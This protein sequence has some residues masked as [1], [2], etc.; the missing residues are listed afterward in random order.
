MY[1]PK[2]DF[3]LVLLLK[4]NPHFFHQFY[5]GFKK[6][7]Q[8]LRSR[9][10]NQKHEQVRHMQIVLYLCHQSSSQHLNLA[11]EIQLLFGNNEEIDRLCQNRYIHV[12]LNI[13]F[14]SLLRWL[15]PAY[16]IRLLFQHHR[17][18]DRYGQ[19]CY[20]PFLTNLLF[21]VFFA[22]IRPSWENSIAF[23]KS[24]RER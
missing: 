10:E 11:D 19:G 8:L 21:S 4:K 1:I 12:L 13:C 18:K 5:L 2:A 24:T 14:Q 17:E 6:T 3:P 9:Q 16:K 22:M 15:D 23:S 20:I 7:P